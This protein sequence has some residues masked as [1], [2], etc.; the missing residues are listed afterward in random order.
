MSSSTVEV[1]IDSNDWLRLCELDVDKWLIRANK[2]GDKRVVPDTG[3]DRCQELS[4]EGFV[5]AR[6]KR[7]WD[8]DK[9]LDQI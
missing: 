4:V 9:L 5:R 6:P 3:K 1:R 2:I 7:E 8:V